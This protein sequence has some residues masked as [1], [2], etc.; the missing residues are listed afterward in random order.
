[1]ADPDAPAGGAAPEVKPAELADL[2]SAAQPK[3]GAGDLNLIRDIPVTLTVE[4]GRTDLLIQDVLELVPGKVIGL[5][6]IA[7][8]PLD[9]LVNGKLLAK[10]EVVVVDDHYGIRLTA[11]IDPAER[12]AAATG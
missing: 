5:D 9:L 3:P 11:I 6:R 12:Q 8:D 4:L 7:G 1:M 10:G 2:S